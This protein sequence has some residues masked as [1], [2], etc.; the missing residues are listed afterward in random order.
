MKNYLS[1]DIG[2]TKILCIK[3]TS[4]FKVLKTIRFNT[5]Q[6]FEEREP[7]S[8][9]ELFKYIS[10]QFPN[11]VFEKLGISINCAINNNQITHSS[12][13]GG[14]E[15][16]NIYGI[17]KKY[18]KF[19]SFSSDNDVINMAKA[20]LA[21]GYGKINQSFIY[22][23]LGTG[24]RVVAVENN[25]ILRGSNNMAGEISPMNIWVEEENK[26][27]EAD[28]L[29]AGKGLK[30]LS[31]L[32][33]G[34]SFSPEDIFNEKN[35]EIIKMY[36]KYLGNFL[37]NLSY[38]YNPNIFVFGG[39]VTKAANIWL[40]GIKKYYSEKLPKFMQAQEFEITTLDHPA[41]IGALV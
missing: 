34:K 32:K 2:G 16:V 37:V 5:K 29:L 33:T 36:V 31:R 27:I 20:E 1:I 30:I 40:P 35:G 3:Y 8:L 18:I 7:N 24:I 10:R 4:N 28:N 26:Y 13:I 19:K 9:D 39:S 25:N 22:V 41:S 38:F 6:F 11:V 17:A 21:Y 14:G 23:N 15:G 12:L